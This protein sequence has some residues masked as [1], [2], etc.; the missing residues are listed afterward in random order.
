MRRLTDTERKTSKAKQMERNRK[1]AAAHYARAST[2]WITAWCPVHE[3]HYKLRSNYNGRQERPWIIC[4]ACK[5]HEFVM[6]Q[7]DAHDR[8]ATL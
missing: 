8:S 6:G 4:P 3:G 5:R 2:R 1:Y 7:R